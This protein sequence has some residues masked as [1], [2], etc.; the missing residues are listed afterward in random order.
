LW[1]EEEDGRVAGDEEESREQDIASSV[2]SHLD[3]SDDNNVEYK[4]K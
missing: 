3:Q 1:T 4:I 2:L